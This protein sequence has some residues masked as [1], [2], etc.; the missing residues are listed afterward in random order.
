MLYSLTT[1]PTS[2]VFTPAI[3]IDI[4]MLSPVLDR[5]LS[6]FKRSA[7]RPPQPERE[8]RS[9][10]DVCHWITWSLC[11]KSCGGTGTLLARYCVR[12][13]GKSSVPTFGRIASLPLL[14]RFA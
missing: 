9:G 3:E 2:N 4:E 11:E 6:E 12:L 13:I 14:K 5:P 8:S 10:I 7:Q 1:F